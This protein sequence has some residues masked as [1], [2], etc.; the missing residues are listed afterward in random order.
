VSARAGTDIDVSALLGALR[1]VCDDAAAG[2]PARPLL[3]RL[4]DSAETVTAAD[5]AGYCR[6]ERDGS[7]R[8]M[9]TTSA[10]AR[11]LGRSFALTGSATGRLL[12]TVRRS[13]MVDVAAM[14]ADMADD[15]LAIGLRRAAIASSIAGGQA[16]GVVVVFFRDPSTELSGDRMT[17]LEMIA[18]ACAAV[19]RF[20]ASLDPT[21]IDA[22]SVERTS[23]LGGIGTLAAM[24]DGLAV[25]GGNQQVVTW[26]P[27]AQ[28][29]TG[30]ADAEVIGRR[31]PFPVPAP[32]TTLDHRLES[33]R[34][35]ALL[36]SPVG[37]AGERVVTFRDVTG[38][39]LRDEARDLFLATTSHEL[40]T[41][42]TV[43][44]G[45]A[46][47]LALR[48]H[49]LTEAERLEAVRVVQ[50]RTSHLAGLVERML[51]GTKAGSSSVQV[52]R[53][54]F[55]L[56]ATLRAATAGL[57][58]PGMPPGGLGAAMLS[59]TAAD[60]TAPKH[61]FVVDLPDRPLPALGDPATVPTIVD[62]LVTNAVKY[63]P[64]GGEIRIE[65][66]VEDSTVYL[67]VSD[68]GM[69][70]G[71]ADVDRAFDRFWQGETGD[72]RRFA[73]VGLGLYILRRLVDRQQGW[74]SL[75]R[76]A[77]GG[78]VALVRWVRANTREKPASTT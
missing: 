78:T 56:A 20:D 73:G 72:Q 41:P 43:V 77:G 32:G 46:D 22:P 58:V 49:D 21:R 10:V 31:L 62:E 67:R 45:Y 3:E 55:D 25:L 35:I 29:L 28:Y 9:Y 54:R 1:Q 15:L 60:G 26:N 44:K 34:W 61:S 24:P 8:V 12:A 47:T 75:Q 36:C 42:L 6:L 53:E 63:S 76:R 16:L 33:G 18:S 2:V 19:R 69:G 13:R 38:V 71:A 74:I 14:S 23:G 57:S 65:A 4:V 52:T 37:T 5:A 66:G 17:V 7:V 39:H 50:A 40:R 70:V 68:R 27:A 48:W 30:L 11:M 59:G 51:L 64:E